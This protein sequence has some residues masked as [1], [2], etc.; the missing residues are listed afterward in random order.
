MRCIEG[1]AKFFVKFAES[2][3]TAIEVKSRQKRRKNLNRRFGKTAVATIMAG[4]LLL[5][6]A[7]PIVHADDKD[8]CRH[9]IEKAEARLDKAIHD[10]GD[11]SREADDRRRDLN[12]ERERCWNQY[13]QWWNG[14]DQRWETEHNWDR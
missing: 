8:K 12:A 10:K 3:V 4:L 6:A 11:H 1:N 2:R 7:A 5:F 9:A 13:H 14:K